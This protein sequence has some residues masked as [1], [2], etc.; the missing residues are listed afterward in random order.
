MHGS[1][2]L[3]QIRRSLLVTRMPEAAELRRLYM[4][5]RTSPREIA[6][7]YGVQQ[8]K[9][10]DWFKA[11]GIKSLGP[12]HLRK[13][14]CA[15]W[16]KGRKASAE[17]IAKN[18]SAHIGQKAHNYGQGRVH[19][20]CAACGSD[21]FDKPYRRK[22]TCGAKCRGAIRGVDHWNY[23]GVS[24]VEQQRLRLTA[25]HREWKK[26]V[27]SKADYHCINCDTRSVR[28]ITAHHLDS[29]AHQ[30]DRRL[31]DDN[32]VALCKGCHLQFHK[33][34]GFFRMEAADFWGWLYDQCQ[35]D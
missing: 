23:A 29:F 33:D 16:N 6:T 1:L 24:A 17:T 12:T 18:S 21:V 25:D 2:D 11:A 4:E 13:G 28:D 30:P 3:D 19:F 7:I 15:Q 35:K 9:V 8:R 22:L 27:C 20:N 34:R 32:G 5:Q 31:A 14:I 10:Y 26:R